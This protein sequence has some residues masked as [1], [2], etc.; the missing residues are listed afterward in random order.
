MA[1]NTNDGNTARKD[2]K[3]D[4]I[5]SKILGIDQYIIN[6]FYL[7]LQLIYSKKNINTDAFNHYRI[8]IPIS[9][10][11]YACIYS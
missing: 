1:I 2:Y 8:E 6:R 9:L 10:V 4:S 5:F 11:Q 3:N 7:R